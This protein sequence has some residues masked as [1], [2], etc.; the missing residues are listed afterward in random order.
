[1]TK[2]EA[3]G[4]FVEALVDR[5]MCVLGE[6]TATDAEENACRED[7]LLDLDAVVVLLQEKK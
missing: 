6:Y 4:R 2:Q 5:Y 1:M 3:I 7:R